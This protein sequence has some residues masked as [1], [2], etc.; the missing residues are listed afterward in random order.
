MYLQS[1]KEQGFSFVE[2]IA[3]IVILGIIAFVAIPMFQSSGSSLLTSRDAIIAALSHAQQIAM[4]RDSAANPVTLQ[5]SANS[6]AVQENGINVAAP[7]ADY[8]FNLPNGV[9]VTGG[10]RDFALRQA[11]TDIAHNHFPQ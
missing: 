2:L 5:V 11:G 1:A 10:V 9:T 8:P 3:T 7:G 4:A 6:V